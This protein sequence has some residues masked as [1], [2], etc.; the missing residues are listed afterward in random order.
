MRYWSFGY[1]K[2]IVLRGFAQE[3]CVSEH[4]FLVKKGQ[5]EPCTEREYSCEWVFGLIYWEAIVAG[6]CLAERVQCFEY[7]LTFEK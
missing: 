3:K 4:R 5:K 1:C 6:E 2:S 7:V